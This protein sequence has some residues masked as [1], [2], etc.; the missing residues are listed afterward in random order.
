M[1]PPVVPS[2]NLIVILVE[3]GRC[4]VARFVETAPYTFE[5][6]RASNWTALEPAAREAVTA[7]V[8]AITGDDQGEGLHPSRDRADL[9][10]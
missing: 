2:H 9:G 6:E 4:I 7:M 5:I 3:S 1:V 8:G 10:S